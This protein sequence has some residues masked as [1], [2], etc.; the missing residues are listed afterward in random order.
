MF[1]DC[2]T[3]INQMVTVNHI[4]SPQYNTPGELVCNND[5]ALFANNALAS[6][7]T[8]CNFN[9]QWTIFDNADCYTGTVSKQIK[10]CN[11]NCNYILF[12]ML[13][14]SGDSKALVFRQAAH[15]STTHG[16]DFTLS[17]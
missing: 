7:T 3:K 13:P 16:G 14:W 8:T 1:T 12:T 11:R 9:A 2:P 10:S 6:I 5:G 15:L 17:F 4:G